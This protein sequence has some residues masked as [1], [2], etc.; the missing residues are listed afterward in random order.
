[1]TCGS[2]EMAG[3][4]SWKGVVSL[5]EL[6]AKSDSTSAIRERYSLAW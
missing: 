6:A 4:T 1:M 2:D 3:R 5:G